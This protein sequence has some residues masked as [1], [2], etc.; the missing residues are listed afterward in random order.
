MTSELVRGGFHARSNTKL[1]QASCALRA[2]LET[3]DLRDVSE[4]DGAVIS[5]ELHE[6]HTLP[7][8]GRLNE[9]L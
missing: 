1:L 9:I 5:T 7:F 2:T 4:S 6:I 8:S 3:Y